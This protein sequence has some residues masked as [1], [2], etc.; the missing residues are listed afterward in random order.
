MLTMIVADDEA[1]VEVEAEFGYPTCETADSDDQTVGMAL[2]SDVDSDSKS[3]AEADS[4]RDFSEAADDS[5]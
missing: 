1:S 3:A 2:R 5:K 4:E